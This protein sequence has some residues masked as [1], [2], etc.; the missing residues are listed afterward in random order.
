MPLLDRHLTSEVN[1]LM[2]TFRLV[3]LAGA[4]Q[5]GKATTRQWA[6]GQGVGGPAQ[7]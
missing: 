3:I 6:A 7:L 1:D 4:R 2:G 5:T